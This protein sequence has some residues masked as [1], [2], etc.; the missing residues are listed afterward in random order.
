[1]KPAPANP[2]LKIPCHLRVSKIAL[3]LGQALVSR[4]VKQSYQIRPAGFEDADQI[5]H[6]I[7][8][9]PQELLPRPIGEI[10]QNIDRFLVCEGDGQLAGVVSWH[11]LPEI[12]RPKDPSVEIKSLA[13]RERHRRAGIGSMLVKNVIDHITP[14]HPAKIIALTFSPAFFSKLGFIEVPKETLMHKIYMGCANCAKY[15]SPFTCPERAMVLVP[16]GR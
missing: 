3:L 16:P 8:E 1:M 12:G 5:F 15:D 2:G 11:I 7:R 9:F 4:P 13:V 10:V 6:L 14:L